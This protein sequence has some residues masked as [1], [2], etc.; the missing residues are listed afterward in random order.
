MRLRISRTLTTSGDG[1]TLPMTYC[2]RPAR[3]VRRH[4]AGE[5]GVAGRPPA[6]RDLSTAPLVI[7]SRH[8]ASGVL[9]AGGREAGDGGDDQDAA[10]DDE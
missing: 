7:G 3:G 5:R 2:P 4:R 10:H 9:P 6:A 8:P 1:R